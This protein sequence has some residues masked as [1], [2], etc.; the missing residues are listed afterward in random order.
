MLTPITPSSLHLLGV[1]VVLG[2][3]LFFYLF[4]FFFLASFTTHY[5]I[6]SILIL[7][8]RLPFSPSF[9]SSSEKWPGLGL[10]VSPLS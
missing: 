7:P 4:I 2:S 1:A 10:P 6:I 8:L 3:R 9:F 5:Q